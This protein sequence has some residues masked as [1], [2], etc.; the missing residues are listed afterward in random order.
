MLSSILCFDLRWLVSVYLFLKV[1]EIDMLKWFNCPRFLTTLLQT[2][3]LRRLSGVFSVCNWKVPV[4]EECILS[5]EIMPAWHCLTF[6]HAVYVFVL[7][8]KFPSVYLKPWCHVGGNWLLIWPVASIFWLP[9]CFS[10]QE[11]IFH[12][13]NIAALGCL[14]LSLL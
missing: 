4:Y 7:L 2:S 11:L 5:V 9:S 14:C 12:Y 1:L 10:P 8:L 3:L 6:Q 13:L